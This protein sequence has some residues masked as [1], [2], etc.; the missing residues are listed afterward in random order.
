MPPRT[1]Q[2]WVEAG[3]DQVTLNPTPLQRRAEE[4]LRRAGLEVRYEAQKIWEDGVM[5]IAT[6]PAGPGHHL[7]AH[8]V[9]YT[10][11]FTGRV[12]HYA[13]GYSFTEDPK[14]LRSRSFSLDARNYLGA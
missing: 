4:S 7:E 13:H 8:L 10:N 6:K 5:L 1:Y 3:V 14:P 12:R 9:S 2:P 11:R